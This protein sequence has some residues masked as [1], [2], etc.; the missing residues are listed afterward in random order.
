MMEEEEKKF[1]GG[2]PGVKEGPDGDKIQMWLPSFNHSQ[3]V[4]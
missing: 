4:T 3:S 2:K 1:M